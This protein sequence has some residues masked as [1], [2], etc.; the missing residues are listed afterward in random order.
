LTELGISQAK[1]AA[2]IA[3]RLNPKPNHI[4]HSHL[5]RTKDTAKH[6]NVS[7]GLN[8]SE[9]RNW[10]EQNFGIW[11]EKPYEPYQTYI[12][13]SRTP[14]DGESQEV[15]YAR[16]KGAL[17]TTLHEYELPLIVCHGGV[18]RGVAAAYG[19]KVHGVKN[20]VLYEFQ[21]DPANDAFP[22]QVYEYCSETG[23]R[24]IAAAF[25]TQE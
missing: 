9:D 17:A 11:Q 13:E 4:I 3:A 12:R 14:P 8:F 22:W 1:A 25:H 18:I 6:I 20:C 19:V 5:I 15:F 21:P 16:V 23:E 10:A 24:D 7:L 2:K